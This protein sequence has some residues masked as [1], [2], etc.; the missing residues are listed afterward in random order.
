VTAGAAGELP[1]DLRLFA[2]GYEA[3]ARV[4]DRLVAHMQW[5]PRME[6]ERIAVDEEYR[7][8]GIAKAMILNA[9]RKGFDLKASPDRTDDGEGLARS[10]GEE[11]IAPRSDARPWAQFN[12]SRRV[13][14]DLTEFYLRGATALSADEFEA[15]CQRVLDAEIGRKVPIDFDLLYA[16]RLNGGLEAEAS[17]DPERS[18]AYIGWSVQ[19]L[20][21]VVALHECAHVLAQY[22]DQDDDHGPNWRRTFEDLLRRY[23]G[24]NFVGQRVAGSDDVTLYH[25]T[26][27]KHVP[28]IKAEG[29]RAPDGVNALTWYM[30]TS[31]REQAASYT[32]GQPDAVVL[33][34][35]VPRA[36]TQ[37]GPERVL[38]GGIEHDVYGVRAT[39]YAIK[40]A[41]S[42]EHLVAVHPVPRTAARAEG[43]LHR[44]LRLDGIDLAAFERAD[45]RTK[46]Q[47]ILAAL[48]ANV[49][50][51]WSTDEQWARDWATNYLPLTREGRVHV[52]VTIEHPGAEHVETDGDWL[53]QRGVGQY[54]IA[55]PEVPLKS[56]APIEMVKVA[57]WVPDE[58]D[59]AD[60]TWRE[61]PVRRRATALRSTW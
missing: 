35:R 43:M 37:R 18:R 58:S 60:G 49:G 45:D 14:A 41:L 52:V 2:A 46:A 53:V 25:G 26:L 50:Q 3:W 57:W 22:R 31:S 7:R 56:G 8:R 12:G 10:F 9:I 21:D 42:S 16:P 15:L 19:G 47:T 51:H 33:E 6:V 13:T 55:E 28:A 44:G 54:A 24:L 48:G 59:P 30:L 40:G 1:E 61:T 39:V 11:N 38:F 5:N 29:L 32:G 20:N 36:L 27:A 23:S 17:W 4:G 34:Y